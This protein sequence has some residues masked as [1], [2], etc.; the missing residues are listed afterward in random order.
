MLKRLERL[1]SEAFEK[2][3]TREIK[4]TREIDFETQERMERPRELSIYLIARIGGGCQKL[5]ALLK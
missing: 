1:T 4:K 3:D 2:K 5:L